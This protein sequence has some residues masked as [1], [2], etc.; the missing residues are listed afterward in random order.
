MT[1]GWLV[2]TSSNSAVIDW[3]DAKGRRWPKT[4]RAKQGKPS[5]TLAWMPRTRH[6][7]LRLT[8]LLCLLLLC[9]VVVPANAMLNKWEVTN[10]C[11]CASPLPGERERSLTGGLSGICFGSNYTILQ[12]QTPD[13]PSKPCLSCTKQWCLN[14]NLPICAGATLGDTDPDTATGKEGDVEARC[15]RGPH[16]LFGDRGPG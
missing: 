1:T 13:N 3:L 10:F 5:R 6:G 15:F 8:G 16:S 12:M 9:V 4:Q 14:Q 7:R 11:K 2:R